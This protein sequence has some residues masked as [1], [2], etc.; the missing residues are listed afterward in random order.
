MVVKLPIL[1]FH[2][3]QSYCWGRTD[4]YSWSSSS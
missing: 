1:S 3:I 2:N 4:L